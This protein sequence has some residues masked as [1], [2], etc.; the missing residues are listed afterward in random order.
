[1]SEI[2]STEGVDILW[3]EEAHYLSEEQ[4]NIIMPTIRKKGSQI[5]LIWNP[6]SVT[7]FIYDKFVTN[8]PYDCEARMINH[9]ENPYLSD[10]MRQVISDAYVEDR[11]SAEHVYGGIPKTGADKAVINLSYILAA[12][13]AHKKLGWEPAGQ[14][15]IGFD[16]A[17]DGD[18]SCATVEAYGNVAYGGSEWDAQE[19]EL[20]K[21]CTT[22]HRRA[23]ETGSAIVWDSIGVGAHCGAKFKELNTETQFNIDYDPFNAG[24]G[25]QDPDK[26]YMR[27]PHVKIL[28]KDH[29]ANIKA[30]KWDEVATKF[31]KTYEMVN[32]DAVHPFD[33]LISI[34]S[35]TFPPHILKKLKI[36]LSSPMKD[37]DKSGRFKVESKE[38]MKKRGIKSPN[39][40]DAFIMAFIKPKRRSAGFFDF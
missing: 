22:V 23:I 28:N 24:S 4:W 10:T 13:D 31:R 15:V 27:L 32:G 37:K 3:L 29:F 12:I 33:E 17:D 1:M 35:E 14:K 5:W 2:K 6:D 39:I 9:E 20:L 40:A 38:D 34:D 8:T 11:K 18:D 7:D 26:V 16:V 36:E 25:V 30:Q 19:D 21:S